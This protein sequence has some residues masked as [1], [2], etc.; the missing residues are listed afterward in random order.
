MR[1]WNA[2][3]DSPSEGRKSC[4][5]ILSRWFQ[6]QK[7]SYRK[8]QTSQTNRRKYKSKVHL[9]LTSS[10]GR[11]LA[12][13]VVRVPGQQPDGFRQ[14]QHHLRQQQLRAVLVYLQNR[15]GLLLFV[16]QTSSSIGILQIHSL[17]R[18]VRSCKCA[19]V[20]SCFVGLSQEKRGGGWAVTAIPN[21]SS[22]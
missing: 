8:L 9:T 5:I 1:G 16:S 7:L 3:G 18:L 6:K 14:T 15:H 20:L 19:A 13:A 10:A 17:F 2:W 12:P 21:C 4:P 22:W 11:S